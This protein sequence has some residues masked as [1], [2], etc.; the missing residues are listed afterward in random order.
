MTKNRQALLMIAVLIALVAVYRE[1]TQ[2]G[3]AVRGIVDV[4]TGTLTGVF[5]F[6][7]AVMR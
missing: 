3:V 1:P 2:S 7:G 5:D 6:A 4:L